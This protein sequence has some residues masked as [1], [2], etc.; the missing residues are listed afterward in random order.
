M[1]FNHSIEFQAHK[2]AQDLPLPSGFSLFPAVCSCL[3][4]HSP[5]PKFRLHPARGNESLVKGSAELSPDK[6]LQCAVPVTPLSEALEA[7]TDP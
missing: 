3:H 6:K 7:Q 1:G 4:S 5:C 2:Q